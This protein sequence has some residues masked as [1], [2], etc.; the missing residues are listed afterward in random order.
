MS[1]MSG[2][3]ISPHLISSHLSFSSPLN[4][5]QLMSAHLTH[6]LS[7]PQLFSALVSSSHLSSA[8]LSALSDHRNS[9]PAQSLLQNQVSA[10]KQKKVLSKLWYR[11]FKR[12]MQGAKIEKNN[13]T[14]HRGNFGAT[15]SPKVLPPLQRGLRGYPRNS[16]AAHVDPSTSTW[17]IADMQEFT[18]ILRSRQA[19][20]HHLRNSH[21]IH[22][23]RGTS[24]KDTVG[25]HMDLRPQQRGLHPPNSHG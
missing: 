8:L 1:G 25:I 15:I 16:H 11:N 13:Q 18:W 17:R 24:T 5:S 10:P 2:H 23:D 22:M 20:L 9:C 6:L 3:L 14:T 19:E 7:S 4:S 12:K 21:A